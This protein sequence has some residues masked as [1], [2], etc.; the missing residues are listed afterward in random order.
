ME[1]EQVLHLHKQLDTAQGKYTYFLLAIAASA[2][3]FAAQITKESI[4]ELSLIPLGISVLSWGLSFYCGCQNIRYSNT[5]TIANIDLF[6]IRD[7]LDPDVGDNVTLKIDK[8]N[9]TL[10]AYDSNSKM[11]CSYN[12]WQFRFLILGAVLFILWRLLE[13]AIRTIIG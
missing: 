3:A 2:I 4:F 5:N 12:N 6:R 10:T 8:I 1:E 11:I 13:M 7:G 9:T